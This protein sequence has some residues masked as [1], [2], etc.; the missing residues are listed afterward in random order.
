MRIRIHRTTFAPTPIALIIAT[1]PRSVMLVRALRWCLTQ[2]SIALPPHTAT[3]QSRI[4]FA[5]GLKN[6]LTY[7]SWSAPNPAMNANAKSVFVRV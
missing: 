3:C 1:P 6:G 5:T 2:N 4:S 7:A